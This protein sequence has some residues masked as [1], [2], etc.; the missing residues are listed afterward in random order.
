MSHSQP[1]VL[2]QLTV[3]SFSIIISWVVEEVCYEQCSLDKTLLLFALFIL[4]SMV[5]LACYSRYLLTSYFGILV[6][7]DEKDI[8]NFLSV[9]SRRCCKSSQNQS[10][11]ASSALVLGAQTWDYC[12]VEWFALETN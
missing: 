9:R 3:Q 7:Y 11:S 6:C 1:Q 8:F 5:K 4:Y 10:S 12:D 2:S